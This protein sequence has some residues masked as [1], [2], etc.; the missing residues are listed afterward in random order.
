MKEMKMSLSSYIKTLWK[1]L[2]SP[3]INE[4]HLNKIEEGIYDVTEQTIQNEGAINTLNQPKESYQL[5]GQNPHMAMEV[6]TGGTSAQ[7]QVVDLETSRMVA[8][9]EWLKSSQAFILALFDKDTGQSKATFELRQD[10]N[11]YLNGD[12]IVTGVIPTYDFVSKGIP[13]GQPIVI[14][15]TTYTDMAILFTPVREIGIYEITL[16]WTFDYDS[17]N[18]SA[19]FQWSIDGGTN[20]EEFH[21]EP[22]DKTDKRPVS[23]TFPYTHP[24]NSTMDIILQGKCEASANT[25]TVDFANII[26]D[27]K[28]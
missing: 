14:T 17:T 23:Y 5:I 7:M 20:W 15:S 24:T 10:G 11:G 4:T 8:S 18:K 25:L 13:D 27:R 16:S 6:E 22:K 2:Q 3:A 26:F 21:I 28:R 12:K 1:N 9:M 19:F